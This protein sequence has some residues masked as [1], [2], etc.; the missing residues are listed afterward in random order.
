M[1]PHSLPKKRELGA[2]YTPPALSQV[3]ADWA[4]QRP[5]QDILEPSFGGCGF[6]DSCINQLKN[7]GCSKPEKQLYGVDIDEHAFDILSQKFHGFVETTK[8]FILKDFIKV[9]PEDFLVKQF[10][11]VI[12][13]P[14]YVSMHNMTSEQ[15]ESCESVLRNSQFS[16]HTIGRNAS[17]WAFFLLHSL[18]FLKVDGR[19][20]WVL[21]SSLLHAHYADKLIDIHRK[22]FSSIKILKLAERFF[23][24]E[25]AKETSVIL[26][27][28]GFNNEPNSNCKL[29]VHSV[30]NIEELKGAIN[31]SG[32]TET[33]NSVKDYKCALLTDDA[34]IAYESVLASG[35]A[36]PLGHYA[37]IKIGMVTGANKYFIVNRLTADKFGLSD[38][39]LTP[40]IGRFNSLSGIVHGKAR[41]RKVEKDNHR[42]LLVCPTPEYMSD[43]TNAVYRYLSQISE[44]ERLTNR[45]FKKRPHWF[46]PGWGI[47]G[48]I[49]DAFLSYMIH[50]S[51][52]MVVNQG[53][54]NCT[55]SIHKVIFHDR[56]IKATKKRAIAISMLSTFS[57]LSAEIEGRSY[58][59]GVLKIEPTAG[60]RIRILLSEE[61]IGVLDSIH[62]AVESALKNE[63]HKTVTKLVD[64]VLIQCGLISMEECNQLVNA[65]HVLRRERYKGVREFNE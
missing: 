62:K 43:E 10:D 6:F 60:K 5:D 28:E 40:V 47:D 65:V 3:L 24:E 42:C 39:V 41:Q 50:R 35:C 59:S 37:D 45:T 29:T 46:A 23:K 2:Y 13:N 33:N 58:S 36:Q 48:I 8:R 9:K 63:D 11:V 53:K 14:P 4:I 32:G 30:D 56:K 7:L 16:A 34:R 55:N 17:L 54:L 51:P 38:E 57:Q 15:R 12:G 21:P 18:S 52:R 31:D 26:V 22:Y 1:N 61:S 25:G 64:S 27:A 19:V 20:A 49:P 44:Q